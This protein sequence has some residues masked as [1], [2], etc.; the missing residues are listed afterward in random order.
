[1]PRRRVVTKREILP[2]PKYNN[3][4]VARFINSLLKRGKKSIAESILYGAFDI[5]QDR[6]KEQPVDIFEKA[7]NNVKPVI[8]AKSRRVGGSADRGQAEGAPPPQGG[9]RPHRPYL[10]WA[11]YSSQG[12]D[13]HFDGVTKRTIQRI[14]RLEMAKKK[15]ERTKP[16][17]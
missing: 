1:M 7:V 6:V 13:P 16:H 17:L 10:R 3:K 14:R 12:T 5:I 8:E 9:R 15:F 2:D 11:I 4:L